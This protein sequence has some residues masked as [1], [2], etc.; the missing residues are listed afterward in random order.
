MMMHKNKRTNKSK[1]GFFWAVTAREQAGHS[2]V[3]TPETPVF[4]AF[5]ERS[6]LPPRLPHAPPQNRSATNAFF[7]LAAA[8]HLLANE[9]QQ[10][11]PTVSDIKIDKDYLV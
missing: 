10:S 5:L 3:G 11:P 2:Y 1:R 8:D 7:S 6:H 4:A 9:G